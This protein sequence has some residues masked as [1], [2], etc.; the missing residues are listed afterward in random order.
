MDEQVILIQFLILI[1]FSILGTLKINILHIIDFGLAKEY[2]DAETNQHIP[3]KEGKQLTG[4]ARYMSINS[5]LRKE[6]SRRDDLEAIGYMLLYFLREG[7]LPWIGMRGKSQSEKFERI[8]EV[9]RNT[10]IEMLCAGHPE[11][12]ANYMRYV[13]RLDFAETPDYNY[14]KNLFIK[15]FQ[16]EKFPDDALYDWSNIDGL[17]TMPYASEPYHSSAINNDDPNFSNNH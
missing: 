12:F 11:E 16:K 9:K 8:K 13:R 15:L 14:L 17:D 4:T 1:N 7:S 2:I 10:P 3:Y 5:H 6:L